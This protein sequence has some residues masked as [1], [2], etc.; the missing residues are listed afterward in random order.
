MIRTFRHRGLKRLYERDDPSRIAAGL[1]ERVGLA[2][3]DLDSANSPRDID[4]PG[5]RLHSLRGELKGLWSISVSGNWRIIPSHRDAAVYVRPGSGFP[6][7][8]EYGAGSS[9]E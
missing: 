1:V 6:P 7:R 9:R 3:A 4:L 8:I 5:Y 2:L